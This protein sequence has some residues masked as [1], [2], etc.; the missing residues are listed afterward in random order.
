MEQVFLMLCWTQLFSL[1]CEMLPFIFPSSPVWF[2]SQYSTIPLQKK[3]AATPSQSA[4]EM[5]LIWL[6]ALGFLPWAFYADDVLDDPVG[7]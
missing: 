7:F 4:C 2:S 3:D 5:I 1:R 6:Q